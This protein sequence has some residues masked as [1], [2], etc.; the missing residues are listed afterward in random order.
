MLTRASSIGLIAAAVA[1]ALLLVAMPTHAQSGDITTLAGGGVGDGSR[2][3]LAALATPAGIV[4]DSRGDLFVADSAAHRVRKVDLDRNIITT[5]AGTGQPGFIGD[6]G[7][8]SI[9][10]LNSPY[11]LAIDHDDNLYIADAGNNRIRKVDLATGIITTVAGSGSPGFEGDD[12]SALDAT[13][14]SPLGVAVDED[15]NIYIADTLNNRIRKVDSASGNVTTIAGQGTPGSGG[16]LRLAVVASLDQ[17]EGV[18]VDDLGNVFIADT[19]NHLIR[20]INRQGVIFTL[21]GKRGGTVDPIDVARSGLAHDAVLRSP[22]SVALDRQARNLY[23]ADSG[24]NLVRRVILA[25][26]IQDT[27][28]TTE[29]GAGD[30]SAGYDGEDRFAANSSLD[31][32]SG[33][34]VNPADEIFISDTGN[35]RVRAVVTPGVRRPRVLT[36]I[37]GNGEAT[38]SGERAPA[39][40]ATLHFPSDVA[41]DADGNIYFS[42]TGNHRVRRVAGVTGSISTVAGTRDVGSRGEGRAGRDAHLHSPEGLAFDSEGDL[43]IADTGNH[44][45]LKLDISSGLIHL[46]AGDGH[47]A[48][49]GE[50]I[51]AT[52][53]SLNSP[54]ALAIDA[55][56]SLYIAD[57]ENNR[58]RVIDLDT[59]RI[60]TFAGDG[61]SGFT[62]DGSRATRAKL[63]QPEGVSVDPDGNIVIADTGNRR[64]RRVDA[65]ANTIS[66]I[67]GDGN[68]GHS[69]DGGPATE[70][71]LVLPRRVAVDADGNVFIA[72]ALDHRIRAVKADGIMTTVAGDGIIAHAGD[73]GP[74][75]SASLNR[76]LGMAP[77]ADGNLFSQTTTTTAFE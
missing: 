60:S 52:E 8:A 50:N 9:A 11:G 62:G 41:I 26:D 31:S 61:L 20:Q 67:A 24:N 37:A 25:N 4:F 57:A 17:P 59:G 32:P 47:A 16:D 75:I 66:T 49:R 5:V 23:V 39:S 2:P 29:A 48:Y 27:Q 35:Q 69:G 45:V 15:K 22:L 34:A 46:I 42:D 33:V 40:E 19:G 73:G 58:I 13:F 77:D 6:G 3:T 71:S 28:I 14:H 30:G 70:A 64:I 56:D 43:Y 21:A 53:A 18:A 68:R 54:A 44:R 72:D 36:T 38:F 63:N 12:G 65:Q 1:A 10:A 76:P 51:D 74:A 55:N 7:P